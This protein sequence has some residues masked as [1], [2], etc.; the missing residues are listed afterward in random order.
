MVSHLPQNW[1]WCSYYCHTSKRKS[2]VSGEIIF[3][4]GSCAPSLPRQLLALMR[5]WSEILEVAGNDT[6]TLGEGDT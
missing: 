4:S 2:K 6:P 1:G 3:E 5:R